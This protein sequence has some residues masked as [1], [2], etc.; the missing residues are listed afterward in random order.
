MEYKKDVC[1]LTIISFLFLTFLFLC[2]GKFGDIIFDCGRE[3][4]LPQLIL[5]GKILYK[6]IFAMYN[7][8]S[9][10][11]NALL[12]LIFGASFNTLFGVGTAVTYLILLATYLISRQ[13]LKPFVAAI[14]AILVICFCICKHH[15]CVEFIFPYSY[16]MIYSTCTF[17]YFVLFVVL[18]VKRV[19]CNETS[20]VPH[21]TVILSLIASLLMG[22]S[23]AC[24]FEFVLA[25][26]PFLAYL[27]IKVRNVKVVLLNLLLFLLPML[28]SF[29]VL[30][31]QGFT[32]TDLADYL[33]FGHDFFN[34]EEQKWYQLTNGYSPLAFVYFFKPVLKR[35]FVFFGLCLLNIGAFAIINK[36]N[37]NKIVFAI[38]CIIFVLLERI[39]LFNFKGTDVLFHF[40]FFSWLAL[41]SLFILVYCFIN[42]KEK[43]RVLYILLSSFVILSSLRVGFVYIGQY[44]IYF[45]PLAIVFNFVF[46]MNCNL[47]PYIKN[48]IVVFLVLISILNFGLYTQNRN[49]GKYLLETNK[50]N[51]YTQK[52]YILVYKDILKWTEQNINKTDT[53]LVL[54][55][56]PMINFITGNPTNDKYYHL[57]PNHIKA[58]GEDRI[59]NDLSKNKPDYIYLQGVPYPLYGKSFLGVDYGIDIY[60]FIIENYTQETMFINYDNSFGIVVFKKHM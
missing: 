25:Y 32:Y 19:S 59:I 38:L 22:V 30:F 60:K 5:Q 53:I 36:I 17:L 18:F 46:F 4:Y 51:F 26:L 7:P 55:E 47:K 1:S 31:L 34:T 45:L 50:G 56:S 43:N 8:L 3:A 29:G 21:K 49:V 58:L 35:I 15:N 57:I 12:Y 52:D 48:A 41:S 40:Q 23:L 33:Q 37:A 13:F 27:L 24:R 28:L 9:Y 54:P 11:I 44:A 10:Q 6:E 14:P 16:G 42:K 39:F 2:W 20:S